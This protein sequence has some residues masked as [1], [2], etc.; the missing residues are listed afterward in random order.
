MKQAERENWNWIY[1]LWRKKKNTTVLTHCKKLTKKFRVPLNSP[2]QRLY[3]LCISEGTGL[4]AGPKPQL[5]RP[6]RTVRQQKIR[7]RLDHSSE[8]WTASLLTEAQTHSSCSSTVTLAWQVMILE[9]W[10]N[11]DCN[12]STYKKIYTYVLEPHFRYCQYGQGFYYIL[13]IT[14]KTC[15][16]F[17]CLYDLLDSFLPPFTMSAVTLLYMQIRTALPPSVFVPDNV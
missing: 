6:P 5:P 11:N 8:L 9:G 12:D 14:Y 17:Q 15:F 3:F 16:L 2:L 10:Y 7:E 1:V 13:V 4:W